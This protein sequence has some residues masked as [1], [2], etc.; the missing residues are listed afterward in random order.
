MNVSRRSFIR[1]ASAGALAAVETALHARPRAALNDGQRP[2]DFD[3]PAIGE[4]LRATFPDLHRHF[5]F[6][7][8][9]WYE[10]GPYVH[11]DQWDRRPPLDL[12][13][14][15]MPMLGAYDSRSPAVLEQ[16][17]R[18]IAE[19]GVG[20][21]AVAW[22][23]PGSPSDRLVP[24][25]MD[26][27]RDHDVRVTFHLDSYR[28]DRASVYAD[29]I[30]YLL[31]QYGERRRWD[32]FLLLRNADGV[33][34]P[35]FKT[36]RTILPRQVR[37]CH[38]VVHD[39]PDYASNDRWRQQT[40]RLRAVLGG[41]FPRITLLADS[42]NFP[43]TLAC[44]FDGIAIYDNFVR[45]STWPAYAE[46][47]TRSNLLFS[48]NINPG[49][50]GIE[51]RR[52]EPDSCYTPTPFEPPA[53]IDWTDP[54]GREAARTLSEARILESFQTTVRLQADLSL[55]NGRRGFFLTY[56]N[57]FNEWH[58]G[59]QFEPMK[60]AADL[61]PD[62]RVY[63]YHNPSQGQYRLDYLKQLL[64]RLMTS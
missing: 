46:S 44:G 60:H 28:P 64:A 11:W 6:E 49:Y 23:G 50:D 19:A 42:L 33:A 53:R 30:L 43:S 3:W 61:T 56:V 5:V 34:G 48:F 39:V 55:T 14:T 51:P 8:Y 40:D 22:W 10:A 32:T 25:L 1:T 54:D 12:A 41:A 20:A 26:V 52:V 15:S 21:I 63:G 36:F 27:M 62:E 16:H 29:D 59:H 45:P 24:L 7:Y 9:P 38:G 17:A 2:D 18:W 57:S 13:A 58:E 37:D 4:Q 31:D 47:C 35:V